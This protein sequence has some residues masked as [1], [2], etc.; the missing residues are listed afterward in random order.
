VRSRLWLPTLI[1]SE[2]SVSKKFLESAARHGYATAPV[3][4]TRMPPGIP[5]IVGNEAAERFSFYGMRAILVV[6]MTKYLMNAAGQPAPMSEID[7]KIYYHIFVSAV[8]F[9]PLLGA[10]VADAFWGKYRTVM[11]LSLV[12]CAGHAALA[13]NDTRTGLFV[14]LGL[15]SLG[16]GGIKPC[17]SAI[18]GDQF[19]PSN[20]HLIP[21]VFSWFYFSINFGSFF[22]IL[23]I[24]VI[25]DNRTPFSGPHFAFAVPGVFMLIATIVFWVGRKRFVQIPPGGAR[26]IAEIFTRENLKVIARLYVLF[27]FVAVFWSLYDQ[28]SSAWVLQA[29]KMDR[30]WLGYEWDAAQLQAINPL[31]ILVMIPIFS[32]GIYP[33]VNKLFPLDPLRKMSIGLFVMVPSFIITAWIESQI[34]RGLHPN[35]VWQ[36]VAYVFLTAAE[37]LVSITSLEF[38]YTQAPLRLKSFIMSLYLT[39]VTLGDLFVAG[40]N[41]FIKLFKNPDGTLKLQGAAYYWF[42]TDI[43]VVTAVIFI[44]VARVFPVRNIVPD[45]A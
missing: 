40:V 27:V 14:G 2:N 32:Y 42:F 29:E 38:S 37:V 10:L 8:Y 43:M 34:S 19:G 33:A 3:K 16:A 15:I 5:F 36:C 25:L 7:A 6:F 26:V 12:Y 41:E 21:R 4:T 45:E 31:L 22:S 17:V 9:L 20:Q 1:L 18:V 39:S 24:P 11:T 28:S 13:I 30:H 23:L 44:F 35:I